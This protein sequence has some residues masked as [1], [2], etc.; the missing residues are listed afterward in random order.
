MVADINGNSSCNPQ[1]LMNLNGALYF[2]AYTASYGAQVWASDGTSGGTV[3]AADINGSGG[4]NPSNLLGI[5][6]ALYFTATGASMWQLTTTTP[7]PAV[8]SETPAAGATGVSVSTTV[9]ATFNESVQSSTISFVLTG[10]SGNTVPA[11]VTYNG[12]TDTA[13]LTPS[14]SLASG[15]TYTATVS[16]ARDQSG[17]A[18]TSPFSWSFT[19]ASSVSGETIWSPS[20]APSNPSQPDNAAVELGVK[21]YADVAGYITGIRF[22]KGSGNTGTHVAHLW[23]S[24]G[25]LLATAT[26][27]NESSGGWQQVNFSTPVA[28]TAGTTYIASYFAPNGHYASDWGYFASSGANNGPLHALSNGAGGGDGVYVYNGGFPHQTY[29]STNYWVDVVFTT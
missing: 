16:G 1:N 26:F 20:S 13:T 17:N 3:M 9:T 7:A 5:G 25:T 15:T 11:T 29:Q 10:P 22:Y 19:T 23:T 4:C 14:A 6:S 21:F 27:T 2:S 24:T 8:T 12:S 28:I 18:M